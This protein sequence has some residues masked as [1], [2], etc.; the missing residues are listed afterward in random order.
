MSASLAVVL[1]GVQRSVGNRQAAFGAGMQGRAA[2]HAMAQPTAGAGSRP[3]TTV[4]P[5]SCAPLPDVPGKSVTTVLVEFPPGAY[6]AAHR[7]P[8]SVTAFVVSGTVRSQMAGGPPQ[9]Y[10][11]GQTW[12]EAPMSLHLFAEN[13]SATDAATL[14]ATFIADDGCTKLVIPEHLAG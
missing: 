11:R 9:D 14:L 8:G 2:H 4:R 13:P 7:H 5:L 12:F 3:A 6:T 10:T 1:L